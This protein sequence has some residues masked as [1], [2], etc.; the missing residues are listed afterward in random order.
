MTKYFN[1]DYAGQ[2]LSSFVNYCDSQ[3]SKLELLM[4]ENNIVNIALHTLACG[5]SFALCRALPIKNISLL[6]R[7]CCILLSVVPIMSLF[8]PFEKDKSRLDFLMKT[9]FFGFTAN[10]AYDASKI[11]LARCHEFK[12][13]TVDNGHWDVYGGF[14]GILV[15][16]LPYSEMPDQEIELHSTMKLYGLFAF[17]SAIASVIPPAISLYVRREIIIPSRVDGNIPNIFADP[18]FPRQIKYQLQFPQHR[19]YKQMTINAD[20]TLS[21]IFETIANEIATDINS[22]SI[23]CNGEGCSFSEINT[24]KAKRT[25]DRIMTSTHRVVVLSREKGG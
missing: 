19:I 22:F 18:S 6:T 24:L 1:F 13:V 25:Y 9:I 7:G 15:N 11:S 16:N 3:A 4:H 8:P 12:Q 17:I 5:A 2:T 21:R 14:L 20:T 10:T 23:Q